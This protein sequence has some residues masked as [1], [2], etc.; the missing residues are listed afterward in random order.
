L[1]RE[2]KQIF[3]RL[4][5][6]RKHMTFQVSIMLDKTDWHIRDLYY[7]SRLREIAE[8]S[9]LQMYIYKITDSFSAH[10]SVITEWVAEVSTWS[11]LLERGPD[12]ET[13]AKEIRSKW[14]SLSLFQDAVLRAES[15]VTR[16]SSH[17]QHEAVTA[18]F[19]FTIHNYTEGGREG[20]QESP[21][22][23]RAQTREGWKAGKGL[24][25]APTQ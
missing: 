12:E 3:E 7:W 8:L 19:A 20:A 24:Q 18:T 13:K 5:I 25:R 23:G 15:H 21:N 4:D 6:I 9:Q 16:Q 14:L 1:W 17:A 22:S 2:E 10:F 11:E